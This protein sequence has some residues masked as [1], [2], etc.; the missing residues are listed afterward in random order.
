M[1]LFGQLANSPSGQPPRSRTILI[2][3]LLL[4]ALA[5]AAIAA[6]AYV[7]FHLRIADERDKIAV[8]EAHH[9]QIQT[10]ILSAD[11][12]FIAF[13]LSFLRDQIQA[14]GL[15]DM[16]SEPVNFEHDLLS[17]MQNNELFDQIRY[18]DASGME[19][20]RVDAGADEAVVVPEEQLQFKGDKDYFRAT[21]AMS[22]DDLYIS[23]MDLNME[24][25]KVEHPFK[26]VIRFGVQVPGTDGKPAGVL[27]INHKAQDML[28]RFRMVSAM[29]PDQSMLLNQNGY[30]LSHPDAGMAWGFMF[31]DHAHL[32]MAQTDAP[33][34]RTLQGSDEGQFEHHGDIISF[35]TVLPFANFSSL[36]HLHAP[37]K[38]ANRYWK[39]VSR[40]P[41][42]AL[43][44]VARP[45]RSRVFWTALSTWLLLSLVIVL[46]ETMRAR[47]S[48]YEKDLRLRNRAIESGVGGLVLCDMQQEHYPIIYCNTAFETMT[49]YARS[50]IIGRNCCF[51]QNDDRDQAGIATIRQAL[52]HNTRCQTTLRNYRKDGSMFWN[53]LTLSPVSGTDGVITHYLGYQ[54]DVTGQKQSE[55]EREQ[56]LERIQKLSIN[57]MHARDEERASMALTLHDEFAQMITAILLH[58]E[59]SEQQC[60]SGDY[61]AAIDHIHKIE[62]CTGHLLDNARTVIKR[63]KPGYLHELGLV[64][65]IKAMAAEWQRHSNTAL[66]VTARGQI[67]ELPESTAMHLYHIVQE[68]LTNIVRHAQASHVDLDLCFKPK[69]LTI[70]ISDNGC[71]FD[72][73]QRSTG[74]GLAGIAQRVEI[75]HGTLTMDS[76]TD[77]GA[78]LTITVPTRHK[79]E[80]P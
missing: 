67:I 78:T 54:F 32:T 22:V 6:L 41:A 52:E 71:G 77:Q 42:A 34:W 80:N 21:I 57:L 3:A 69:H 4:S 74:N 62:H 64:D 12:R 25:G 45:I 40:F 59:I 35:V 15:A 28:D 65:A 31:P 36:Q 33:L 63:L 48:V 73:K 5:A 24:H 27:I 55:L 19:R 50:E 10:T 79:K 51:L 18:I 39:I 7:Y 70:T 56:L 75:L 16:D 47:K 23:P 37:E 76:A 44:V 20:M 30:W 61:H 38:H 17:V 11:L 13:T 66:D 58:A 9:V 68:G 8:E 14:H 72:K 1:H 26:P 53:Q 60:L 43:E 29:R 46:I 2:R 49:G